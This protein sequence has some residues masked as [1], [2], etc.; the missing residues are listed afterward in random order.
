MRSCNNLHQLYL[1]WYARSVPVITFIKYNNTK[2]IGKKNDL[3]VMG[4]ENQEA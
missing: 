4:S 2:K 1:I 3:K